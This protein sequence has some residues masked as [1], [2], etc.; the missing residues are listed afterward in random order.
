MLKRGGT[1]SD[2]VKTFSFSFTK[3][4]ALQYL[5]KGSKNKWEDD[6]S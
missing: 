2:E 6:Y 1:Y 3:S 5:V 4:L